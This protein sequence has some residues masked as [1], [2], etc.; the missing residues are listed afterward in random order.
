MLPARRSRSQSI[1]SPSAS[2]TGPPVKLSIS[3]LVAENHLGTIV[4]QLRYEYAINLVQALGA[5]FTRIGLDF[6]GTD[7]VE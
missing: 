7:P 3:E 5:N 6:L 4:G 2:A 1:G